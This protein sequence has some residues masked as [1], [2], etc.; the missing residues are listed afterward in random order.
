MRTKNFF[1]TVFS[2]LLACFFLLLGS[3]SLVLPWNEKIHAHFLSFLNNGLALSAVG[4]TL[5][6]VG[7]ILMATLFISHRKYYYIRVGSRA[8]A[9]N[10]EVIKKSL[11]VYW[12]KRFGV[13][14]VVSEVE[15]RP[16][17]LH[18][19]AHLPPLPFEDQRDL[20]KKIEQELTALL[21]DILGYSRP[22][23]LTVSFAKAKG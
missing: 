22:L 1:F 23:F 18:I 7:A 2:L 10:G 6:I 5:I 4:F 17:R 14:Q 21:T 15:I 11:S 8:V 20:V 19:T 3:L 16:D 9:V 13:N 12:K